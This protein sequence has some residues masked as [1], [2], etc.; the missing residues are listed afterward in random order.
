MI[1][2]VNG[3]ERSRGN[4]RDLHWPWERLVEQAARN[5]R[6]CPGDVIGS[7]TVGTGCILEL[8]DGRWLQRG[9]VVGLESR[10][11][12]SSATQSLSSPSSGGTPQ[13]SGVAGIS[14]GMTRILVA[15]GLAAL[16]AGGALAASSVPKLPVLAAAAEQTTSAA[17]TTTT[18]ATTTTS[19]GSTTTGT[20]GTTTTGT[21]TTGTTTGTTT[22]GT[23]SAAETGATKEHKVVLCHKPDK[24][25]GHAI[26]VSETR[27]RRTWLTAIPKVPASRPGRR[28]LLRRPRLPRPPRR[29]LRLRRR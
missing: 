18:G 12:A 9:V 15:L 20:T 10:E 28:R 22:T 16:F 14:F 17:T 3:E 27:F 2:R 6:L 24:R 5:T 19:T 26:E 4:L 8:G 23:T 21:T 1:A 11:S 25:G 29:L 7:G 13:V